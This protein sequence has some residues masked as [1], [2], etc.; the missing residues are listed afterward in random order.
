MAGDC[1]SALWWWW[2]ERETQGGERARE[3]REKRMRF[4]EGVGQERAFCEVTRRA[5]GVEDIHVCARDMT[6]GEQRAVGNVLRDPSSTIY[7]Q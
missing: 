3:E 6:Q 5:R 7:F 2:E 4:D 1:P